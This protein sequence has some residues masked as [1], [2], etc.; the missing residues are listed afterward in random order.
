[1]TEKSRRRRDPQ[2]RRAEIL[3]AALNL[4]SER[5]FAA[6]RI[7]DVAARAG[8]AKGTVYLHFPDKEALF[9]SLASGM[10]SPILARMEVL[11]A[12]DAMSSR[13]M[14]AG[15]YELVQTEILGTERRHM[16]RLLLAEGQLFPV[17]TEFYHRNVM[18]VGLRILRAVL[19]RAAKR[20][21][22]RSAKVAA[23]PQVV[24]A[25]V[26]LSIIWST[27]FEP[28]EHLDSR[29]LF[30]AFLDTLFLPPQGDAS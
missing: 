21:E 22:L 26:L 29:G 12:N 16:L 14:V 18:T 1:M 23:V 15:L 8:I 4:F 24:F 3:A 25:P 2:E 10:A 27:L 6:T 19:E 5:G 30:E 9:T 17:V 13:A 7:E 28:Y 20:G 11:A